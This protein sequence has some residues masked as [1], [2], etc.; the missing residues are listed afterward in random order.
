MSEKLSFT[1][2]LVLSSP[3]HL[4]PPM[5]SSGW[6]RELNVWEEGK[7]ELP[8]FNFVVSYD[9]SLCL[10]ASKF[11]N[12]TSANLKRCQLTSLG[13]AECS[14]Y[15]EWWPFTILSRSPV[16]KSNVRICSQAMW[17]IFSLPG[18]LWIHLSWE[19][20]ALPDLRGEH[21]IA[22]L[23]ILFRCTLSY[24]KYCSHRVAVMWMQLCLPLPF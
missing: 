2:A 14:L 19:F 9:K 10:S 4:W 16:I 1:L 3:R 13:G 11:L 23:D 15:Q 8:T 6:C 20:S 21:L 24:I 17:W 22:F 7:Q 18:A 12:S 5:Q